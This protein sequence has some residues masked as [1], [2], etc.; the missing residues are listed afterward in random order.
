MNEPCEMTSMYPGPLIL[1]FLPLV[2]IY[3]SFWL[4]ENSDGSNG[5]KTIN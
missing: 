4:V 1:F 2:H 3:L 5:R